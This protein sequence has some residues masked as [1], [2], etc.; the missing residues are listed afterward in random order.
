MA[1]MMAGLT[2][3]AQ[4]DTAMGEM[5]RQPVNKGQW[6]HCKGDAGRPLLSIKQD[7]FGLRRLQRETQASAILAM[8]VL[9][10][11]T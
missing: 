2:P 8:R 11:Q 10:N 1:G 7:L 5:K 9:R 6:H 4:S 3:K